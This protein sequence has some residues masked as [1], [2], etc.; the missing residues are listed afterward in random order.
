[1][2]EREVR[3]CLSVCCVRLSTYNDNYGLERLADIVNGEIVKPKIDPDEPKIFGNRITLYKKD[4]PDQE[5]YIGVWN[6]SAFYNISDSSKDYVE[7][8]FEPAINFIEVVNANITGQTSNN[9]IIA[10]LKEGIISDE[11]KDILFVGK[12]SDHN[13]YKAVYLRK[14]NQ[15]YVN[16]RIV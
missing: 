1:M 8:R 9:S 13:D 16:G 15:N 3:N 12:I 2:I 6:W 5:G 7:A 4:G 11:M 14:K 10:I